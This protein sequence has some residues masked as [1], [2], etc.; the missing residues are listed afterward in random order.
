LNPLMPAV[1]PT[2]PFNTAILD[3]PSAVITYDGSGNKS[4]EVDYGYDETALGAVTSVQHD[5]QNFPATFISGRG[6]AT[7][8]T[9]KCFTL[10]NG[11]QQSCPQGDSVT[12]YAFDQTGQ[13][14]SKTD[15]NGNTTTYSFSDSFFDPN[16]PANAPAPSGNTNAYLIRITY[17]Q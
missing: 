16:P 10:V 4:A 3:R 5:D 13:P 14:T 9:A 11:S 17:P 8:Q 2:T 1:T 6:N 7:T 12:K 15:P